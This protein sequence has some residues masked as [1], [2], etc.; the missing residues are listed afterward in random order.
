TTTRGRLVVSVPW[1][2][3]HLA[4][5]SRTRRESASGANRTRS[6][7]R[8]QRS[9]HPCTAPVRDDRARAIAA[10]VSPTKNGSGLRKAPSHAFTRSKGG[11][12]HG[13]RNRQVVQRFEG[14]RVHHPR[15]RVEGR[16]RPPLEHPGRGLQVACRGRA[17]RVRAAPGCEGS[18]GDERRRLRV[19]LCSSPG[20]RPGCPL[21]VSR[22]L[23]TAR[24][25][26][27]GL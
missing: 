8:C 2:T 4:I 27:V 11:V 13:T 22:P 15:G 23:P 21:S 20:G 10:T 18:R 17:R 1:S 26:R 5:P 9:R 14:V 6:G 16:V 24:A 3:G 7:W 25:W 12:F 19:E